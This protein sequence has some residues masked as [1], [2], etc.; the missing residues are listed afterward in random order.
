[1]IP[2]GDKKS[3]LPVNVRLV[4]IMLSSGNSEYLVTNLPKEEFDIN[5][6]K[7]IYHLRWGIE[8]SFRYLKY[9][10]ALNSF[11]SIRRDFIIQEIY[12]KV[13]F[14]NLTRLMARCVTLPIKK[15][16]YERKLS[17]SDAIGICRK[18]LLHPFKEHTIR[19]EMTRHVTDIRPERSFPRKTR[20][21][22]HKAL[23]YRS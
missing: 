23:C 5:A 18:Y 14:Y 7:K 13:I 17:F 19:D 9:N 12:A 20:S 22:R 16:K 2:P 11:N 3:I 8:T 15:T 21:Q 4:K 6:L 1:M 10:I